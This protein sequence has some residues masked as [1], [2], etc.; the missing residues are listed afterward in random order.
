MRGLRLLAVTITAGALS[1]AEEIALAAEVR[2][3]SPEHARSL[4]IRIERWDWVA[5]SLGVVTV[6][7]FV[8]I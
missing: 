1:R 7:C 8:L 4:H 3:F 6:L 5:L 2:A